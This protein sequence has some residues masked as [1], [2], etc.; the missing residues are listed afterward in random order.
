M[1]LNRILNKK[2]NSFNFNERLNGN[3]LFLYKFKNFSTNSTKTSVIVYII[4]GLFT[5]FL[6][7]IIFYIVLVVLTISNIVNKISVNN[8]IGNININISKIEKK[9][10]KEISKI[11]EKSISDLG[12][13]KYNENI[14]VQKKDSTILSFLSTE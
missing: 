1:Q 5:S 7:L 13:V 4:H 10:N 11:N 14:F 9:Y 3:H 6:I 12:F 8:S 2:N